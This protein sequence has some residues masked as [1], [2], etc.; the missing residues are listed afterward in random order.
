MNSSYRVV[1]PESVRAALKDLRIKA[2]RKGIG[3]EF[4]LALRTIDERLRSDPLGFG[5]PWYRL[6]ASK[7]RVMT[8]VVSPLVVGYAVHGEK[9][10]VFVRGFQPFPA[11]AF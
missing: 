6:P 1:Y 5:D 7:L 4:L 10:L 2:I 9:S 11:D 8:R 3:R